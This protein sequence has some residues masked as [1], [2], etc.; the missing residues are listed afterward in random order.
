MEKREST[1]RI[2]GQVWEIINRERKRE[3]RVNEGI[4]IGEWREHFMELL[5]GVE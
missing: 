1:G 3:K 5:S 4:D 2:Y